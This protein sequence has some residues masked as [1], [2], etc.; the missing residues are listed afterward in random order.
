M[1]KVVTSERQ[2]ESKSKTGSWRV[3]T[4]TGSVYFCCCFFFPFFSSSVHLFET[5]RH[6]FPIDLRTMC[7]RI[8]WV[9][10]MSPLF[11][12]RRCKSTVA[13]VSM[14]AARTEPKQTHERIICFCTVPLRIWT[15]VCYYNLFFF[16]AMIH[17]DRL[18]VSANG[19]LKGK[20]KKKEL[21][22]NIYRNVQ[23]STCFFFLLFSNCSARKKQN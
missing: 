11:L 9:G 20:R 4:D 7:Q 10:Q 14:T 17:G 19:H 6:E 18:Q 12:H 2:R 21:R 15:F 3:D 1:I 8:F 23:V 22:N 13:V 5:C 16:I